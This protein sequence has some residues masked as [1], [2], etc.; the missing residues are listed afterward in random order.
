MNIPGHLAI[1][2]IQHRLLNIP[3]VCQQ[4]TILMAV[5]S[6]FPDTV[7]KTVGYIFKLMPNGRHYAH[8]LFGLAGTTLIIRLLL[9]KSAGHAW[10]AGYLGHL[11]ADDFAEIPWFFPLL[12][13]RFLPGD[14][15]KFQLNS[16]VREALF[17]G[18]AILFHQLS[19]PD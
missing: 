16:M 1:A 2:V 4:S 8:N 11:L 10:F 15:I 9:G 19:Q 13:Y 7:D 14:G 12:S 18:L 3:S 5:S 6:L 17:L